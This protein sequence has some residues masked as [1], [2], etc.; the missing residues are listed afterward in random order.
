M[1]G[2]GKR[3][4]P[5]EDEPL[6]G[7][8]GVVTALEYD[9]KAKPMLFHFG[10]D[11]G[12]YDAIIISDSGSWYQV[13]EKSFIYEDVD[14]HRINRLRTRLKGMDVFSFGI[15]TAPKSIKK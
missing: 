3:R 10:T 6:S 15:T 14:G 2:D 13:S 7:C 12:G 11:G 9:E 8:A 4:N 1:V 5:E